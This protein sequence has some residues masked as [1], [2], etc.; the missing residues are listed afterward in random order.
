MTQSTPMALRDYINLA[1]QVE[2]TVARI[3][4]LFGTQFAANVEFSHFWRLSAEAER[5]HAATIRLHLAVLPDNS[6]ADES[7]LP[8]A[9]QETQEFLGALEEKATTC[10]VSP[11]SQAEAIDLALWIESHGSEVHGRTQFAF[12]QPTMAELFR[13]LEEEDRV[14]RR[15]FEVAR[16]RFDGSAGHAPPT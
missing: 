13:R 9:L 1:A 14:H 7:K 12:L 6:S 4:D 16:T 11:P 2:D 5:Y 3:Y 10:T 15:T 8:L